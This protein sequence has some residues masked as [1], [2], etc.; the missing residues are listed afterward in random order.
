MKSIIPV[1][2]AIMVLLNI[3][4]MNHSVLAQTEQELFNKARDHVQAGRSAKA[5]V[6]L[7]KLISSSPEAD[8]Y[9]YRA[10]ANSYKGDDKSALMDLNVAVSMSP[11]TTA[12]LVAR[13]KILVDNGLYK[14][15]IKDL[16]QVIA[17]EPNNLKALYLRAKAYLN[18][19]QEDN[20]YSDI[21]SAIRIDPNNYR[22][23]LIRA[24]LLAMTGNYRDSLPDYD[25]AISLNPDCSEAYNNKGV[26]LA[27]LG[28]TR[29]AIKNLKTAMGVAM[30]FPNIK[31]LPGFS[32]NA[33]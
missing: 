32:V 14:A 9:Y 22:Y 26:A 29:E 10:L 3:P 21:N 27:R 33:W 15:A 28:K 18:T 13:G 8:Y 6:I 12:Y 7:S 30:T 11:G 31:R 4:P 16:S 1:F 25:R 5:L 23:Y 19:F 2:I 24:D 20:S 17:A